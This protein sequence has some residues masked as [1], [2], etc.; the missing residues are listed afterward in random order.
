MKKYNVYEIEKQH[1]GVKL[2]DYLREHL[3]MSRNGLIKVKKSGSLKVNGLNVHTDII[4]KAGDK[5]EFELTDQNSENILPEF[6]ELAIIYED[7]YMIVINKEAGIPTHP[8]KNHYMGTLANGLMYH[9]MEEGRDITIRPVNR[10]DKNTSGL[11][12]FAKS[13]HIQHLMSL[14]SYKHK[15]SKEYLAIA[16]GRVEADSGTVDAPIAKEREHSVIRTVRED[17]ARA[18]TH[19]HVLERYE[20]Y[21]LLSI[22]LETGRTHQIRVHMAYIGHPLLGDDLYGGGQEKIKRHA[23]HAYNIKMLHPILHSNLNLTAEL[24]EDMLQCL[25]IQQL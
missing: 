24:P 11:V 5:V 4:L 16:Q 10:L 19:Y 7:E 21:T 12:L 13:S 25:L 15:I 17:G 8:S 1:D 23:L 9:L 18:V 6:M 3:M 20:D 2:G 14:E 22:F